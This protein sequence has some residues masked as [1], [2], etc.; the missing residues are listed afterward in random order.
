V[1][2]SGAVTTAP[3]IGV[4]V[5]P[6]VTLTDAGNQQ[7]QCSLDA[8]SLAWSDPATGFSTYTTNDPSSGPWPTPTLA[9]VYESPALGDT[10]T[11]GGTSF[12]PTSATLSYTT[13]ISGV[14]IS[15]PGPED[16][17]HGYGFPFWSNQQ[18]PPASDPGVALSKRRLVDA[19]GTNPNAARAGILLRQLQTTGACSMGS[20]AVE[21][22][23]QWFGSLNASYVSFPPGQPTWDCSNILGY[24]PAFDANLLYDNSLV[25]AK[26]AAAD[27]TVTVTSTTPPTTAPTTTAPTTTTPATTKPTT[28]PSSTHP[29]STQPST[30]T[31]APA[32]LPATGEPQGL[33]LAVGATLV[34]VG[35]AVLRAPR[36]LRRR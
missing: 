16:I 4:N 3:V 14:T 30:T 26:I 15:S 10:Y 32:G 13:T 35:A 7:V 2:A 19:A 9:D 12:T 31:T 36:R 11:I 6:V 28:V 25:Y 27:V 18:Y 17:E 29:S 22:F 8:S 34:A 21:T 23:N 24:P 1:S 5:F 20:G 33:M